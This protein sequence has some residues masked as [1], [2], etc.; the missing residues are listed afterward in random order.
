MEL[1]SHTY[2]L[3]VLKLNHLYSF[4][5]M[6]S[7]TSFTHS[8]LGVMCHYLD[9]LVNFREIYATIHWGENLSF[10][11]FTFCFSSLVSFGGKGS[12]TIIVI[13]RAFKNALNT[14]LNTFNWITN[15]E[16]PCEQA[17]SQLSTQADDMAHVHVTIQPDNPHRLVILKK[18][19]S[20]MNQTEKENRFFRV[21]FG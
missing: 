10:G 17:Q 3:D 5:Q 18:Y 13:L 19:F 12:Y 9:Q 2:D 6:I 14:P 1:L 4:L 8:T 16:K 15:L 20:K 21:R 7:M 11:N